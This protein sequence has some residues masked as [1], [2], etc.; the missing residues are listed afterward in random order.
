MYAL[1]LTLTIGFIQNFISIRNPQLLTLSLPQSSV[2]RHTSVYSLANYTR[3]D[4]A[5][6]V[7]AF[8]AG[9]TAAE[10]SFTMVRFLSDRER[11]RTI[12]T[13]LSLL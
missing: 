5:Q 12:E 11:N 2:I 6:D 1:C 9:A 13:S 7:F 10:A 4:I 3:K 8:L